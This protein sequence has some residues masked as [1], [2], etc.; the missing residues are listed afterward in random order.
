MATHR[1]DNEVACT[2]AST[3]VQFRHR[4]TQIPHRLFIKQLYF[5]LSFSV[6]FYSSPLSLFSFFFSDSD[7][8]KLLT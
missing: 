5:A 7:W 1:H 6:V 3:S 2:S 8:C 4:L